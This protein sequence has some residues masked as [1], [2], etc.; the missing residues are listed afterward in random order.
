MIYQHR[1]RELT[2]RSH[3][4]W[5]SGHNLL[6]EAYF[7]YEDVFHL[8]ISAC[9]DEAEEHFALKPYLKDPDL[10]IP[11]LWNRDWLD[12]G[13]W[14]KNP[15]TLFRPDLLKRVGDFLVVE[16]IFTIFFH[17]FS[18]YKNPLVFIEVVYYL[19]KPMPPWQFACPLEE[20][21]IGVFCVKFFG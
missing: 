6:L 14:L 8:W 4:S 2:L 10:T 1:Y 9:A 16:T 15:N 17:N 7:R 3:R 21:A 20:I 11:L 18:P 5:M 19:W 12:S 13:F